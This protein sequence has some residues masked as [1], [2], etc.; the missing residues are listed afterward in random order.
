MSK[1]IVKLDTEQRSTLEHQIRSGQAPA[2]KLMHA[3]IRLK[4]D[5]GEHG[6]NW[7]DTQISE[8]PEVSVAT[9]WRVRQR[10]VEGGL[11]KALNR[12]QQPERPSKRIFDG[13]KEAH[14]IALTCA[15]KPEGEGRWSLRLLAERLV[16][17]GAVDQVSHE[18][19]RQ[20]LKK[21]NSSPGCKSNGVFHPK[22][23]LILWPIRRMCWRS[24]SARMIRARRRCAWMK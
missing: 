10:F 5:S 8:A 11:D 22:L 6:P 19:V 7:P 21:T 20:I 1:Y 2:R 17:V 16:K 3:R 13:E 12:R 4:A 15:E 23:M 9:I 18:T 24:P 14:L